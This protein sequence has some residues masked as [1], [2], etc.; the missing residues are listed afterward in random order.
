MHINK[1]REKRLSKFLS[2]VLRHQPD[3]IGIELDGNGWTD[4]T[5]L[6]TQMNKHRKTINREVLTFVVENNA[7]QRFAF[8]EDK[9][10]IRANQGHS[11][12]IDLNYQVKPSDQVPEILY[13]GTAEHFAKKIMQT[14]SIQK[15][16]RHHVHLSGDVETAKIV[17]KRHGRLVVFAIDTKAMLDEGYTFYQADN[18]VWLTDKI[19]TKFINKID[20]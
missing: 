8:N 16:N 2:L 5:K 4:V 7:K 13:H 1:D 10:L 15:M 17:G 19:D 6:I 18:G 3:S 14:G 11:V 20:I 12:N 9:S